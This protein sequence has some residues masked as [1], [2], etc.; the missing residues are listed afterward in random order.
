MSELVVHPKEVLAKA[1]IFAEKHAYFRKTFTL[2]EAEYVIQNYHCTPKTGFLTGGK[3]YISPNYVCFAHQFSNHKEKI[4]FRKI[5]EIKKVES[6]KS[7]VLVMADM[8]VEYSYSGFY[9][10]HLDEAYQLMQYLFSNPVSYIKVKLLDEQDHKQDIEKESKTSLTSKKRE[11]SNGWG[12]DDSSEGGY[13]TSATNNNNNNHNPFSSK[14]NNGNPFSSNNN[15]NKNPFEGNASSEFGSEA[16]NFNVMQVQ[17]VEVDTTSTKEILRLGAEAQRLGAENLAI[18][19]TQAEQIDRIDNTLDSIH[20]KLDRSE[21]LM[22][23]IESLPAYIGS[24]FSKKSKRKIMAPQDRN[25]SVKKGKSPPMDIEILCKMSDDSLVPAVLSFDEDFFSC[26]DPI[27]DKVI[28][29]CKYLY[30]E[31]A[32]IVMRCRPEHADIRFTGGK[33]RFRMM[34]SYLQIITNELFLRSKEAK[35]E[36]QVIFEP[37]SITFDFGNPRVSA[38][39]PLQNREGGGFFRKE[40][41]IKTSALLSSHASQETREALDAVDKDL[42]DISDILFNISD[43]ANAT[44]MELDRQNE[45][46]RRIN[47]KGAAADSRTNGLNGRLDKQLK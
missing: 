21:K 27:A 43:Q 5:S 9:K 16:S 36:V 35:H 47:A 28:N 45:Q 42:D 25:I 7:I 1:Q 32:D 34:S 39:P 13:Y 41:Q 22:R 38:T 19:S 6:E 17:K 23:D 30:T 12:L 15:N 4:P 14:N 18:L 24:T 2:S 29:K 46:L 10:N 3:L 33:E 20:S 11:K 31:I 40:N 44:A 37:Q 8:N 26:I